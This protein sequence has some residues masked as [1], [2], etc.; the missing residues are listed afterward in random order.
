MRYR[1]ATAILI[2][3]ILFLIVFYNLSNK[4]LA[5]ESNLKL[6]FINYN[7]KY[8]SILNKTKVPDFYDL[9]W[10]SYEEK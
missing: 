3:I 6:D 8:N 1:I 2:C 9:T 10:N 4:N 5:L 7:D